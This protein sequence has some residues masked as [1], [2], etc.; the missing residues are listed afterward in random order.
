M[1]HID[2][3]V[4][5]AQGAVV[6]G[7]V[8]LG[9]QS[10]VW[11]NAVLRGDVAPIVVGERS[12]VQDCAVLHGA[13]GYPVVVGDGVTIGHGAIVHGCTVGSNTLIGMGAIVLNGAQ[14]GDDCVIGAGALVTQG[15]V[16]PNGSV[17]F[18]SPARVVR[19]ATSQDRDANRA[20]AQEYV[21]L[22]SIETARGG[23]SPRR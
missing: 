11:H 5:M 9:A 20:N 17:A 6:V 19:S 15:T 4:Y 3:T 22:A 13:D 16:I 23:V 7:D 12:N 14:V 21:H 8:E 18:G 2:K 10:S 1:A